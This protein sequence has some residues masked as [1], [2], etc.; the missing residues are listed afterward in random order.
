VHFNGSHE[1]YVNRYP[2]EFSRF[3]DYPDD[4]RRP[5]LTAEKKKTIDKYDNSILYT[6]Y[7]ISEFIK[8]MKAQGG[9]SFVLY[10][11]DH[12]EEVYNTRDFAGRVDKKLE[13]TPAITKIPLI[14]WLSD[15]YKRNFPEIVEAARANQHKKFVLDDLLWM[16]TELYGLTFEGFRPN[17]SLVNR[18]YVPVSIDEDKP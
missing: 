1:H 11:S 13:K 3:K 2:V 15:E 7:L 17:R 8:T 5:W 18:D 12:G 9:V 4:S 16:V 10:F 6:D 14:L